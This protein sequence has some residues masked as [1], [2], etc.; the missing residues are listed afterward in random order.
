MSS[1]ANAAASSNASSSVTATLPRAAQRVRLAPAPQAPVHN[2]QRVAAVRVRSCAAPE[3]CQRARMARLQLRPRLL[4]SPQPRQALAAVA[5]EDRGR[6]ARCRARRHL[7]RQRV[8]LAQGLGRAAALGNSMAG[9]CAA[10]GCLAPPVRRGA[11]AWRAGGAAGPRRRRVALVLQAVGQHALP[12]AP[13]RRPRDGGVEPGAGLPSGTPSAVRPCSIRNEPGLSW[14]ITVAGWDSPSTARRLRRR[15]GRPVRPPRR[16][17]L[18]LH[19][20]ELVERKQSLRV[21]GAEQRARAA[22]RRLTPQRA[23]YSPS[24]CNARPAAGA[25]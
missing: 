17:Q 23:A 5:G 14:L 2:R 12:P 21:A 10:R 1:A 9:C 24:S 25:G 18:V 20:A 19:H 3:A 7:C 16:D 6:D 8:G 13:W 15:G 22:R 4:Q 11:P